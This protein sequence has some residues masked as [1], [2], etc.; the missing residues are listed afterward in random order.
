[1]TESLGLHRTNSQSSLS[2]PTDGGVNDLLSI[3][4]RNPEDMTNHPR[5]P[6]P[7][8]GDDS[9]PTQPIPRQHPGYPA[10][11]AYQQPYDWRYAQ[12][13]LPPPSYRHPQQ[14]DS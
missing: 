4:R 14:P 3:R 5:Y 12:Q 6:L 7:Q 2:H 11:S 8:P 1:M 10:P 9:N 13:P